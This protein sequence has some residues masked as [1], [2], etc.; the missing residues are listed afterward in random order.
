MSAGEAAAAAGPWRL[1][2]LDGFELTHEG[3]RV[4]LPPSTQRLVAFLALQPRP[5]RRL[6]VAGRLYVDA[7]E[8]R[9]FASLRSALWRLRPAGRGVVETSASHL[10]LSS[11]VE[12]DLHAER[13]RAEEVLDERRP[14]DR[15][16]AEQLCGPG[17]LL[18]DWYDDWLLIERERFRQ[19]R[20]LALERACERLSGEGR[21]GEAVR[22]GLAAVAAEPLRESAHRVVMAAHAAAGN[23]G[24]ALRQYAVLSALVREQLGLEPTPATQQLCEALRAS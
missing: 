24:E 21:H 3:R 18:P 9:A 16:L 7:S 19:V 14:L 8:E 10:A 12:V 22:V 13:R 15:G 20:L 5:M 6:F 2:L 23:R 4:A 1:S 17:E 11:R